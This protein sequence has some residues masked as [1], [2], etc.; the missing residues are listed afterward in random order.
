MVKVYYWNK[1][2]EKKARFKKKISRMKKR[3]DIIY[4][5]FITFTDGISV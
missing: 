1:R 4:G 3:G 5:G 2:K